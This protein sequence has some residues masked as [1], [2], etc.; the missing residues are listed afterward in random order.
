MSELSTPA[1]LGNG[2]FSSSSDDESDEDVKTEHYVT[3]TQTR[4]QLT[5]QLRG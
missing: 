3:A 2:E 5:H 4:H 1:D